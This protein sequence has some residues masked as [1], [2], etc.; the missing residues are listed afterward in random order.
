MMT[1]ILIIG[2][3]ISALLLT[4]CYTEKG[5]CYNYEITKLDGTTLLC[6]TK[7]YSAGNYIFTGCYDSK[8][9]VE[10]ESFKSITTVCR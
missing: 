9:Y 8:T 10:F 5:N 1:K 6:N 2:L 3:L 7:H 4:G